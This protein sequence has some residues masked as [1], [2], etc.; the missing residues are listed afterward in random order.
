MED[1]MNVLALNKE[2][3]E[4]MLSLK[5]LKVQADISAEK[6]E[7]KAMAKT[8][9]FTQWL[10]IERVALM[11]HFEMDSCSIAQ[12]PYELCQRS[13]KL[14]S[15]G[16]EIKTWYYLS[17]VEAEL[18]EPYGPL[19][20]EEEKEKNKPFKG[21]KFHNDGFIKQF[22]TMDARIPETFVDRVRKTY[23]DAIARM[24][25]RFAKI[26][27]GVLSAVTI[28]AVT[29]ATAGTMSGPIAVALVGG[30][31]AG[32]LH[33]AALTGASLA[34]LGGGSIAAGG[35]GMA[36]GVATIV[37]GGA[38]LGL[39]VGGTAAAT[40]TG[41]VIASPKL[42]L[43]TAAKLEVTIREVLLNVQ[44]DTATAQQILA[45]YKEELRRLKHLIVDLEAEDKA[46][47]DQIKELKT[48]IGYLTKS[49]KYLD[50]FASSFE[51]GLEIENGEQK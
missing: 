21:L 40:V 6:D 16:S 46:N 38:L 34:F 12:T 19:Y 18:F 32:V 39:A 41:L 50:R 48:S 42:T 33:G 26:T 5:A 22:L 44:K 9:W 23:K 35:L 47:K 31:Y 25:G 30:Q 20:G 37:G 14:L 51:V 27:V 4:W 11:E 17:V 1:F 3:H 43:S 49:S 10:D 29:A 45:S 13:Q 7:K 36:G 15:E 2:Q 8:K 24:D 28:S